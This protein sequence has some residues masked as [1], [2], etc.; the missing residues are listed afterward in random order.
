V[1]EAHRR[2][3]FVPLGTEKSWHADC[4]IF[5]NA[6]KGGDARYPIRRVNEGITTAVVCF[7]LTPRTDGTH[8]TPHGLQTS[9]YP[10]RL[11]WHQAMAVIL[12]LS[13][14]L[15]GCIWLMGAWLMG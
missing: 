8:M 1:H 3:G 7:R 5:V 9:D 13:M 11:P 15:W 6:T 12:G 14:T 2:Q 4:L 10:E